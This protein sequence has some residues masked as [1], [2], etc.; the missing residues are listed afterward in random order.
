MVP[1]Q[2][3]R[4]CQY[5]VCLK[6]PEPHCCLPGPHHEAQEILLTV[7]KHFLIQSPKVSHTSPK[8]R[9]DRP[10]TPTASHLVTNFSY[11]SVAVIR[12]NDQINITHR[13]K[14]SLGLQLHRVRVHGRHA[15]SMATT[16]Q[17]LEQWLRAHISLH[18]H[19]TES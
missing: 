9:C 17:A 15:W 5:R 16:R 18:K 4:R 11:L 14:C 7:C 10:V 13:K 3:I 2:R 19:K 8:T 1:A 12:H 6:A